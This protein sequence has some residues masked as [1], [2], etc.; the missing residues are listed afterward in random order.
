[1]WEGGAGLC[2]AKRVLERAL[3][4]PT[5]VLLIPTA[6]SIAVRAGLLHGELQEEKPVPGGSCRHSLGTAAM[7][8]STAPIPDFLPIVSTPLVQ[9]LHPKKKKPMKAACERQ[10][11]HVR[12]GQPQGCLRV[13]SCWEATC[14]RE[15]GSPEIAK[16]GNVWPGEGEHSSSH[17]L[18]CSPWSAIGTV[19]R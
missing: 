9:D 15:T 13:P 6:S 1:M 10:G 19:L 8:R 4:F 7:S 5:A 14:F 17:L 16:A 2:A 3:L 12:A 11:H 18:L